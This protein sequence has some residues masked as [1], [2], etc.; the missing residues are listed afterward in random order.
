MSFNELD[1][2]TKIAYD[3]KWF[4]NPALEQLSQQGDF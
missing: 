2:Y 4:W 3:R 1:K